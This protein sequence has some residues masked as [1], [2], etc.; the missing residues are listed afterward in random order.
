[1]SVEAQKWG[2]ALQ[3]LGYEV[4]TV[5]GAGPVDV[6]VDG[7]DAGSWLTGRP[8]GAVD[9]TALH[10]ALA[11]ADLVVVENL[12]SLPLNPPACEAVADELAGR[13]AILRHHDLP[14]QRERFLDR[15]PPP[16][17]PAW[18]HVT[19]N[20]LSAHQLLARGI[21]ATVVRNRFDPDAAPGDRVATRRSLSV[22][23]GRLL[24]LQPTRAIARKR[25][26]LGLAVAERL[27]AVYWLLGPAE[28][29]FGPE[30]EALLATAEVPVHRG[31]V[32]PMRGWEGV[33]HAYAASDVV[34]FPSDWEG[35]GNPPVEAAVFGR[36]AAVG[37]Y[38]VGAELRQLGF[39]WFD[40]AQPA[41][42]EAWIQ[43]PDEELIPH[44]RAVVRAHLDLRRLP[45]RLAELIDAAGWERPPVK[46]TAEGEGA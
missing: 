25:V 45:G 41:P 1:M 39:R 40:A 3:R 22:P 23:D 21:E 9:R 10:A 31:P 27:D 46:R 28:E 11:D 36:P 43:A 20:A 30:L 29:G 19:I 34:V 15:P 18:R 26:D 33:E 16:H 13:P 14:W 44:N 24:V 8:A 17:D 4:R 38:A 12:C 37:S 32:T 2:A 6:K 7:L 35:F 42:L 5:A